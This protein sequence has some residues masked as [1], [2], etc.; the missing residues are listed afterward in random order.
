MTILIEPESPDIVFEEIEK[1]CKSAPEIEYVI[2]VLS[3][4]SNLQF[5]KEFV[6]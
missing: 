3:A 6:D 1:L 2:G 5:F 4:T